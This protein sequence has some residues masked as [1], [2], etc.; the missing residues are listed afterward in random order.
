M[1][2]LRKP[3][4]YVEYYGRL[5]NQMF[6]YATAKSLSQTLNARLV[7]SDWV[8]RATAGEQPEIYQ[9]RLE[10]DNP[11]SVDKVLIKFLTGRSYA[12]LSRPFSA[13]LPE[14]VVAETEGAQLPC[15]VLKGRSI[16]LRGYWQNLL[17]F[18]GIQESLDFD[19]QPKQL[20]G[21]VLKEWI[22]RVGDPNALTMHVRR[23]DYVTDEKV[24]KVFMS[25]GQEYYSQ[26]LERVSEYKKI[27]TIF[28]FS[29][30]PDWCRQALRFGTPHHVV[31]IPGQSACDEQYVMSQASNLAIA[32]STYSWWAGWR[33]ARRGGVVISP[34]IW[35]RGSDMPPNSFLP[36]QWHLI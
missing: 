35:R 3:T 10:A 9:Y 31:E 23:G 25:Y 15:S 33:V 12:K 8:Y 27:A 13:L 22:E 17:N 21:P 1:S 18:S 32:A 16:Y 30:D 20:V 5:G 11:N 4:V 24:S 2:G 19:F 6:Q 29:D 36:E 7:N 14:L 34:R 26:A 28:I